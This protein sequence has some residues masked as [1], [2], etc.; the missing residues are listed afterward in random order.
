[1]M[2]LK[3]IIIIFLLLSYP[4]SILKWFLTSNTQNIS[5]ISDLMLAFIPVLNIFYLFN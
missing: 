2:N 5:V 1:M 3:K 4:M